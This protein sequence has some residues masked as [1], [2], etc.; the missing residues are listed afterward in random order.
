ML[1]K[2]P[3]LQKKKKAAGRGPSSHVIGL[4]IHMKQHKHHTDYVQCYAH[5]GEH[6]ERQTAIERVGD[7]DE[8]QGDPQRISGVGRC[9]AVEQVDQ[10]QSKISKEGVSDNGVHGGA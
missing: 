9:Y 8:D 10:V 2:A 3:F 1:I 4:R 5:F 6:R 7:D